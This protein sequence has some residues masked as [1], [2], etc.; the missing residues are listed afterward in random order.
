[1]C[2]RD[3]PITHRIDDGSLNLYDY[4]LRLLQSYQSHSGPRGRIG[5]PLG[6]NFYELLPFWHTF[7][8]SLGFSVV[9]SPL[10]NRGIYLRG[11]NTIPSATVC[12]PAKLMHGHI[13]T[14]ID[15]GVKYIFYPCM[16][17]NLDEGISD[18]HYNLSLIHI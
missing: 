15:Q 17:Y 18:N 6:L 8:S 9:T 14:L 12:F 4:K 1:M 16:S 5:I 7:F 13:Q 11:Q 3:S 2:I 10:S